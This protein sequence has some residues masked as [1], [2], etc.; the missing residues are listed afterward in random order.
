MC[1]L[2]MRTQVTITLF[3]ELHN[4]LQTICEAKLPASWILCPHAAVICEMTATPPPL[5]S[6]QPDQEFR[7]LQTAI[8]DAVYKVYQCTNQEVRGSLY[9]VFHSQDDYPQLVWHD[10][11]RGWECGDSSH[12]DCVHVH[13]A[14]TVEGV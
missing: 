13:A 5:C 7:Q 3:S 8:S 2:A 1:F 11:H 9:S 6:M 14:A 12:S 10:H 4:A